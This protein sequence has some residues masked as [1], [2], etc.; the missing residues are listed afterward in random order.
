MAGSLLLLVLAG[1]LR[2]SAAEEDLGAGLL[3]KLLQDTTLL[4]EPDENAAPVGDLAEGATVI[5]AEAASGGWIKVSYQDMTG[6]IPVAQSGLWTD[7]ELD[8]EFEQIANEDRLMFEVIEY[9]KSQDRQE[10]I[11]GIVIAALVVAVFAVGI[12]SVALK[13]KKPAGKG[14]K[15]H[16][17]RQPD[18]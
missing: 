17:G 10:L 2:V 9:E 1:T 16:R 12:A 4:A 13:D 7:E 18:A 3:L 14:R 6:Y 8:A 15:Q 11:W 5:S